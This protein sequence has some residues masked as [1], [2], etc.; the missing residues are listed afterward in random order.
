MIAMIALETAARWISERAVR[1]PYILS[2]SRA[3]TVVALKGS[4]G[5]LRQVNH[6]CPNYQAQHNPPRNAKFIEHAHLTS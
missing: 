4:Q 6:C 2:A 3:V 1:R 5:I